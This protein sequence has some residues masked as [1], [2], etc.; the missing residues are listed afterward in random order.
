MSPLFAP[1]LFL[2]AQTDERLAALAAEGHARAFA[3]L[4]DRHRRAL[5][6]HARR[7]VG[8]AGAEDVVQ[9]TL[10]QAWRALESGPE[11][12]HVVPWLHRI[13]H[14]LSLSDI[15]RRAQEAE[16]LREDL[17]AAGSVAS[18][19]EQREAV[20]AVLRGL[21]DLPE[22][23]RLALLG[24]EID[25]RSRR[26]LAD[27]LG[28]SEGAVRQLV[29][30][31]RCGVRAAVAAVVPWP[32]VLRLMTRS[33]WLTAGATP[34]GRTAPGLGLLSGTSLGVIGKGA[35]TVLAAGAIG[36][37]IALAPHRQ[38]PA[39][40]LTLAAP[41]T[42]H[43]SRGTAGEG[44]AL[45]AAAQ[46][47]ADVFPVPLE[48]AG[49]APRR[50][51]HPAGNP[52]AADTARSRARP[53]GGGAARRTADSEP[54][55][56]GHRSTA[57]EGSASGSGQLDPEREVAGSSSSGERTSSGTS[58]GG[59]DAGLATSPENGSESARA[60]DG[61]SQSTGATESSG[62]TT[63]T[64]SAP[65]DTGSSSTDITSLQRSSSPSSGG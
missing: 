29:H 51:E 2:H 41:V 24:T 20:R 15:R 43:A 61:S 35:L 14:N 40:H 23:Q 6:G 25:G 22:R 13:V 48:A 9:Q 53:S 5:H 18:A 62:T 4:I 54:S 28:L 59:S 49:A 30:R 16:P 56:T 7:L 52:S 55:G 63:D 32:L 17:P 45:R 64:S 46:T 44:V 21:A 57:A 37:A 19:A 8:D 31:A 34:S 42:R 3:I 33:G 39:A 11:V 12:H 27:E 36:G 58:A 1:E 65:T 38:P 26:Q 50:S 10:L 47:A 60:P